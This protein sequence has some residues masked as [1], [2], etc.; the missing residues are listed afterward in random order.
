M[1]NV[2]QCL[3]IMSLLFFH[4]T[5]SIYLQVKKKKEVFLSCRSSIQH[6]VWSEEAEPGSVAPDPCS[7]TPE[8]RGE[9]A[10]YRGARLGRPD[11]FALGTG[12]PHDARSPRAVMMLMRAEQRETHRTANPQPCVRRRC[13]DSRFPPS[14]P[15]RQKPGFPNRCMSP[16]TG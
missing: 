16:T 5:K 3:H 8:D 6:F 2:Q 1:K 4:R 14:H 12:S 11:R 10:E 9:K 13:T 15:H 7:R